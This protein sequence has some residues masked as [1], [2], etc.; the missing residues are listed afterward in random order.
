MEIITI[1]ITIILAIIT[2]TFTGLIPGIHINLIASFLTINTFYLLNYTTHQQI[3][4]FIITMGITHTFI[5]FIPAT[6]LGVPSSDTA[7]SLMPAQKLTLKGE[8]YKAIQLSALGSIGG[9]L[10]VLII[11]PIFYLSLNYIYQTSKIII[12]YILIISIII[13]IL[14]ENTLNKKFYAIFTI[15]L[16]TA[17][18]IFTL[19]THL[20]TY[21]LLILFTGIFGT[22]TL[23]HALNSSQN[24]LPKQ[25]FNKKIK[26]NTQFIKAIITGGISS[27]I[28]SITP[29][30][31][32]AQ[33]ASLSSNLFK[34]LDSQLFITTISAI[35]TINFTLSL[36]TLYIINKARNG[37]IIVIKNIGTTLT[38]NDIKF[39]FIIITIVSIL[40]YFLTLFLGKNI[41]KLISKINIKK[42]NLSI[43][44]FLIIIIYLLTNIYGILILIAAT[45]LGLFAINIEIKRIHLMTVLLLPIIFNLI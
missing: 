9:I 10:F 45:S 5:D 33:A 30:I 19:N 3:I 40:C 11:S 1:I 23:I 2:G 18:G 6:L 38:I 12:P 41:I 32:N 17:L 7:L 31:G 16:C 29:G 42:L 14:K 8:S 37:A 24:T 15:L 21:P 44:T 22:S 13:P 43:I 35:N 27:T 36:L 20:I 39:Y 34:H 4:I 25:H 28:C 26:I